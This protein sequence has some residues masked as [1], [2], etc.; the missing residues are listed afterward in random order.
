MTI[1]ENTD[2]SISLNEAA[3][4]TKRYRQSVPAGSI[5][6]TGFGKNSLQ[7]ILNQED[8]AGIRMYFALTEDNK[9]SLVLTGVKDNGNDIYDGQLAEHGA[10]CPPYCSSPNPLNG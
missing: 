5:I 3:Q 4:M 8:C 1:E 2:H 6:A 9:I 7:S 10:D